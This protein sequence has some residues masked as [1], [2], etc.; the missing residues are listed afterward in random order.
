MVNGTQ[1]FGVIFGIKQGSGKCYLVEVP[2]CYVHHGSHIVS[3]D[4]DAH[5]GI[6][7]T[8]HR[9]Y[10]YDVIFLIYMKM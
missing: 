4:W 9:I 5:V 10:S 8:N 1:A 6:K 3:D 7:Q 2:D